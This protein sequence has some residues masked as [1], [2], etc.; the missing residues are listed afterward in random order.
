MYS[1]NWSEEWKLKLI[2]DTLIIAWMKYYPDFKRSPLMLF[3]IMGFSAMPVFFMGLFGGLG[4][5]SHGLVGA[6][7]SMVGFIGLISAINDIAW[8][9]YI[10]IR[11]MIVA[12]PVHPVSYIVGTA[13]AALLFSIP[14]VILFIAIAIWQGTLNLASMV[15]MVP[16]LFL[17]WFSLTAIGF[18]ISTYLQKVSLYMLN[19]IS[20]LLSMIFGF[21]FPVY[22][23]REMLGG[24]AWISFIAPTSTTASLFRTYLGLSASS[25]GDIMIH[26]LALIVIT[27]V[28]L[29][30]ASAKYRWREV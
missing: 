3:V 30:L 10:K 1:L 15:W 21:I 9:R 12:M 29:I 2:K 17:C 20:M 16:A 27:V 18:T 24:Y 23:P 5:L 14:G 25:S 7:V 4:M 8:D 13:L 11:E 28:F 26:W 19:G 22:Y 6:I